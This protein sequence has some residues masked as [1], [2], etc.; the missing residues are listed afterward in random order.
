MPAGPGVT[1][2]NISL[3]IQ[4]LIY[5]NCLIF[6]KKNS[7]LDM[8]DNKKNKIKTNTTIKARLFDEVAIAIK[9]P[10]K[11]QFLKLLTFKNLK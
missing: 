11:K 6:F 5:T 8:Q 1:Q 3:K 10:N 9:K 7:F 4:K 2:K